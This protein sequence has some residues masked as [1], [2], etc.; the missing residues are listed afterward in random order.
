MEQLEEAINNNY[1][2]HSSIDFFPNFAGGLTGIIEGNIGIWEG[3]F[4]IKEEG[5]KYI[6]YKG[7]RGPSI[8]YAKIN[9]ETEY[10]KKDI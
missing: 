9:N 10:K 7:G 2:G 6:V 5:Y 1:D 4:I 3:K 8:L